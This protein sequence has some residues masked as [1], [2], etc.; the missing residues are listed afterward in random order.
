M[1]NLV[2]KELLNYTINKIQNI[3]N[4]YYLY[5]IFTKKKANPQKCELAS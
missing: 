5:N 4:I 3:K 2:D 1:N